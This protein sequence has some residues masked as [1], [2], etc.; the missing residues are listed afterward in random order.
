M[1]HSTHCLLI[2][3]VFLV[4]LPPVFH[5]SGLCFR[6]II[7]VFVFIRFRC[8]V[9]LWV[10]CF[11]L[12]V[13]CPVCNKGQFVIWVCTSGPTTHDKNSVGC[14]VCRLNKAARGLKPLK[15]LTQEL[16]EDLDRQLIITVHWS[17]SEMPQWKD[18][19]QEAVLNEGKQIWKWH[20]NWRSEIVTE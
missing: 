4:I 2:I 16:R 7:R 11:I 14:A 6:Y 9:S 12:I 20:E 10:S 5:V 18:G 19:C 15:V 13:S 1:I 17:S 3:S 8:L